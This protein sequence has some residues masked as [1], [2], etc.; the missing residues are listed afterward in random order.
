MIAPVVLPFANH[1]LET[2]D[3]ARER[4]AAFVGKSA[5]LRLGG[6]EFLR[7]VIDERGL[8]QRDAAGTSATVA[9][10]ATVSIE[11]PADT[12]ARL[13]G[14]RAAVFAA[15]TIAGSADLAQTLSQVFG[16]L[17]WDIEED[18]SQLVGDIAAR[19]G[20]QLAGHVARWHWQATSRL[21][22]AV[23]EYLTEEAAEIAS[24]RDIQGFCDEVDL[25]RDDLARLEKRLSRLEASRQTP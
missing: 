18:L 17:R 7:V 10:V 4:L 9:T 1:L 15:A 19:R 23:A 5:S 11:L 20:L 13:L 25:L 3:W 22:G 12:P 6:R 14:D 21:A 8:L 16:N 24:R 2:D